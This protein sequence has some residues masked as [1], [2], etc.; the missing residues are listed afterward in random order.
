[1]LSFLLTATMS[2]GCVY[3]H[4]RLHSH[5]VHWQRLHEA[6]T[7]SVEDLR[8]GKV[9]P[10]G[11]SLQ[12]VG[13]ADHTGTLPPD[14]VC[15]VSNGQHLQSAADVSQRVMLYRSPGMAPGDAR[16]VRN[17]ITD[18]IRQVCAAGVG[19]LSRVPS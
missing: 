6:L 17:T 4:M 10:R 14:T 15:V 13:V 11:L 19:Q 12:L 5:G 7:K 3:W 2:N 18:A 1:M 9:R 8:L 16:V